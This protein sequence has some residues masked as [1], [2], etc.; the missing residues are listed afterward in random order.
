M[1]SPV[2]KVF[3]IRP[4]RFLALCLCC[5]VGLGA[6]GCGSAATATP[7]P[8]LTA[9]P[10]TGTAAPQTR[11]FN[12]LDSESIINYVATLQLGGAQIGGSFKTQGQSITAIPEKDAY[13]LK[14]DIVFDGNSV[15]GANDLVVNALKGNLEVDKFPYGRFTA[16]TA[17][18]IDLEKAQTVAT[19][20][21][22]TLEL[23]GVQRPFILPVNITINA[24]AHKLRIQGSTSLDLLD[25][26]VNVPTAFLKSEISFSADVVAIEAPAK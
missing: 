20:A 7:A 26:K 13:T 24:S 16:T 3:Q 6:A 23:H 14:L 25:Y 11:T 15:T 19:K 17:D 12:V 5:F 10:P 8:T 21:Q 4:L 1:Y 9:I 22:G 18:P 2:S